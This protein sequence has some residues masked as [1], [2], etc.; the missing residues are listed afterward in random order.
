MPAEDHPVRLRTP[1]KALGVLLA[2]LLL[3]ALILL[4]AFSV[5]WSWP[6]GEQY[7]DFGSFV[8]SGQAASAGQNPYGAY[9]LTLWMTFRGVGLH[10]ACPNLNPPILVP[11]FQALARLELD[12]AQ[13]G[14]Y[15]VSLL[16]YIADLVLLVR[17][18][19][20]QASPLRVAWALSLASLWSTLQLGQIYVPLLVVTTLVW[21]LLDRGHKA[22][23]GLLM[24][25]LV[26]VKPHFTLWPLLVAL[27]GHWA[28]GLTALGS[29]AA[30]SLVVAVIYG[31]S[32]Y[33]QWATATLRF[34]GVLIPLNASLV[35]LTSRLGS[36]LAGYG[37]AIAL[38]GALAVWAW[39]RRP[40]VGRVSEVALVASLLISPIVWVGY[41][42]L[43]LPV[44]F[45]RPWSSTVRLGAILLV[46]PVFLGVHLSDRP[47][48]AAAVAGWAYGWAALLILMGLVRSTPA[49][50]RSVAITPSPE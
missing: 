1:A 46:F 44:L 2:G 42:M 34:E 26:A 6:T 35:G 15:V 17:A 5:Y 39:R 3:A 8:A 27:A 30:L 43:L 40:A 4:I 10:V 28:I 49:R 14:W 22:V 12:S 48:Y 23:P 29:A 20:R 32:I 47:G 31:P 50:Q 18:Y 45:S 7:L 24:G 38:V 9:P 11:L 41:S 16:L 25:L 33:A 36:P 37:L 13:R 19:P 21:L